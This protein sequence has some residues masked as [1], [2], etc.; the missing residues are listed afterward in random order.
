MD[1][2]T[3]GL[4]QGGRITRGDTQMN[5][6][7]IHLTSALIATALFL[8]FS[9]HADSTNDALQKRL[10][11]F[12][13]NSREFMN[14]VPEKYDGAGQ[15]VEHPLAY[16]M[17]Q[18]I[19]QEKRIA[20]KDKL[21]REIIGNRDERASDDEDSIGSVLGGAAINVND[22]SENL[23]DNGQRMI[24]SLQDMENQSLRSAALPQYPWSDSYWP[25][26]RGLLGARYAH[27]S[28][29]RGTR[30]NEYTRYISAYPMQ[31]L[32]LD[33][34]QVQMLSPSEKYDL[35]VGDLAGGLTQNMWAQAN[36]MYRSQG[37]TIPTWAGICHGWAAAAFMLPRPN[38]MVVVQRPVRDS[39]GRDVMVPV[40]FYPADVKALASYLWSKEANNTRF[41]GGRCQV[42]RPRQD[43]SGRVVD[44][45]CFDTN[46]GTWHTSIVN[47]IGVSRRSFILDATY[48]YEV[49]NQ[50]VFSYSYR[51]FNPSTMRAVNS[52]SEAYATRGGFRDRFANYR[53]ANARS[54]VG[55]S[56]SVTYMIEIWPTAAQT[57]SSRN[58]A[59]RTVNYDYDLELD[60][61]G[62]IVGGEWYNNA[63]PDFLWTPAPGMRAV[64]ASDAQLVSQWDPSQGAPPAD[65]QQTAQAASRRGEVLAGIVEA[66]L[67]AA[68]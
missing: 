16:Y 29:P 23:V 65:W 19:E 13:E 67:R 53:G 26:Y 43:R 25:M 64:T 22:R 31:N 54:I 6:R 66:L 2:P 57:N 15:L 35:L 10:N 8:P 3:N 18:A 50:P 60:A 40:V 56:M 63:H 1:W 59:I 12:S 46:P 24:S 34:N 45:N 51:Y 9:A 11:E 27:P 52:L 20:D 41:I 7:A 49:W 61:N 48:D 58:D 21:R 47:Q 55:V 33:P 39:S 28:F 37:G 68:Q 36:A 4:G 62:Q 30:F 42:Q 17:Q 14:R 5:L 32:V 44:L 38:R